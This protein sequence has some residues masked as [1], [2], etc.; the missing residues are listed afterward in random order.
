M[1]IVQGR[2]HVGER[3][4]VQSKPHCARFAR[5]DSESLGDEMEQRFAQLI[6]GEP[7]FEVRDQIEAPAQV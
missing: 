2:A 6:G 5:I 7:R 1:R 4:A 3:G